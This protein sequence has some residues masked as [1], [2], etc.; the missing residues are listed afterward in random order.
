MKTW[1]AYIRAV[2]DGHRDRLAAIEETALATLCDTP[3]GLEMPLHL[4]AAKVA[5]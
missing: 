2:D 4:V 1:S 5:G 3:S